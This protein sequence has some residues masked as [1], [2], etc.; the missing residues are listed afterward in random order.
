MT[1]PFTAYKTQYAFKNGGK[2]RKVMRIDTAST[3]LKADAE[4]NAQVVTPDNIGEIA[5]KI[6]TE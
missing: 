4:W 2:G 6:T 3:K 1:L 5:E